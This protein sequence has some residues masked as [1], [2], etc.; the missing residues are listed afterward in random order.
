MLGCDAGR[1]K[2]TRVSRAPIDYSSA[3]VDYQRIDALKIRAQQAARATAR[4]LAG[5][6][7][8]ELERSRGESA[9]IVDAGG[10]LLASVTECLGTKSLVA[11]AVRSLTGRTHY[12]AVAQDT[13][14]MA[15]ND[16]VTVGATP[17]SVQAYWAAGSSDWFSD[18][19]RMEDLVRGWQAACDACKVAWGGG[20]TP[21]LNGLIEPD[22]VDLA[23]SCVGIVSPRSRLMLGE[24]LRAGDAI[25]LLASSGIHA[26]GV[27]LARKLAE[28]VRAGYAARIGDG[29][30]FGEALLDPTVLYAPVM[31]AVWQAGVTPHYG[32]HVTGHGWRKIMRH[33]GAFTYR[34]TK[35][36]PVPP[37]L[38]FL[39]RELPLDP[40]DAY[41]SLNMGAGFALFVR[42][43]QAE[44]TVRAARAAGLDAWI[45][46]AV[47]AG[48]R[49]V[50]IDALGIVYES[51][52]LRLRG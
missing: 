44:A 46:G 22:R 1:L 32:V 41:G 37:V 43:E 8:A 23:A 20:E 25:V 4:H 13:L 27:S 6:G 16:L 34:I 7:F 38:E 19:E 47:E 49:R 45:S 42:P 21:A 11:D 35:L 48:S 14:A 12:E 39:Q 36:P 29:R 17:I 31:E 52:E 24:E 15:I 9:Y 26:N 30:L 33:P 40:R 3:G 10:V 18:T 51:D 28:R 2:V 50:V 5:H